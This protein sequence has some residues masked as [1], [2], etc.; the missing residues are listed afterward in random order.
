MKATVVSAVKYVLLKDMIFL[1]MK[2]GLLHREL[3]M[4]WYLYNGL[5]KQP[6]QTVNF[7]LSNT[8]RNSD[9]FPSSKFLLHLEMTDT[10]EIKCSGSCLSWH[11]SG[12][13]RCTRETMWKHEIMQ[14]F[15]I[16]LDHPEFWNKQGALPSLSSLT[17]DKAGKNLPSDLGD[18]GLLESF[19]ILHLP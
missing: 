11:F 5:V 3:G 2:T 10:K 17:L 14:S 4:P 18:T 6:I 1:C 9:Y 13:S 16:L 19:K 15:E 8:S 12:V 7:T